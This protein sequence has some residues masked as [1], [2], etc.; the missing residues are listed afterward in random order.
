MLVEKSELINWLFLLRDFISIHCLQQLQHGIFLLGCWS[1]LWRHRAV[2]KLG[3]TPETHRDMVTHTIPSSSLAGRGRKSLVV[4]HIPH[5]PASQTHT[6]LQ[7]PQLFCQPGTHCV[8]HLGIW[9][10][11]DTC[12]CHTLI[13]GNIQ[14]LT[15]ASGIQAVICGAAPAA[16]MKILTH[17]SSSIS[18]FENT[19]CSY[20]RDWMLKTP[21]G[22][23][24][25]DPF[26][27][28]RW[29]DRP[30]ASTP[31]VWLHEVSPSALM[32]VSSVPAVL[33]HTRQRVRWSI[34]EKV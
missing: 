26:S 14:T 34:K 1:S 21:I 23:S 20:P 6:N 24:N 25:W 31:L 3:N 18:A 19:H 30:G 33:T 22:S 11:I 27:S 13:L 17:C 16:I 29:H 2:E 15:A 28:N 8:V 10:W 4:V 9:Q 5:S 7:I 32:L 12:T